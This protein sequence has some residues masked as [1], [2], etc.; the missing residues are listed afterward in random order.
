MKVNSWDCFDTL[1]A[2]NLITPSSIFDIVGKNIGDSDFTNKR[3]K[4][5]RSSSG[6]YLD[7]YKKL[8]DV[9]KDLELEA[10]LENC[11]PIIENINKVKDGDYI[12]SDM[13]LPE[14]FIREMLRK[15]GLKKDVNVVVTR[16][17]KHKGNI[18]VDLKDKILNHTGDNIR[19]DC[20]NAEIQGIKS[21]YYL[22]QKMNL[23]ETTIFNTNQDLAGFSRKLRLLQDD[24]YEEKWIHTKGFFKK[25]YNDNWYEQ[26]NT[27]L[28]SRNPIILYF[29]EVDRNENYILLK[30]PDGDQE[31]YVKIYKNYLTA[32][33]PKR[34]EYKTLYKGYWENPYELNRIDCKTLWQEQANI[35]I[36]SLI[37]GSNI[38]KDINPDQE[39]T[40]NYRDTYF[41]KK[42]YDK[43]WNKNSDHI[44]S[45]R[46]LYYYPTQNY[47]TYLKDKLK[48]NNVI[49]DIQGSGASVYKFLNGNNINCK[50]IFL[51]SL[52]D[53][54]PDPNIF[55]KVCSGKKIY[56]DIEKFNLY[57]EGTLIGWE[58]NQP[59]RS[60]L[61]CKIE[62]FKTQESVVNLACEQINNFNLKNI[63]NI[64]LM[65][66][67]SDFVTESYTPKIIPNGPTT[68]RILKD[69]LEIIGKLEHYK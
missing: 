37:I 21:T 46:F 5:E 9:N 8:P 10:E 29:K 42:I 65:K 60:P 15:C 24:A 12:V 7:I 55:L 47:I 36:P 2:R 53:T 20:R 30:R 61:E 39:Y 50:V 27:D 31:V 13:Y 59:I 35:N 4:A 14:S 52:R 6:T 17:G 33:F 66:S 1:I 62:I 23:P 43:L 57:S 68:A 69:G 34:K 54:A 40:F 22:E 49:V 63:N 32:K 18:W 58:N 44:H 11:Y 3:K 45:S 28:E 56:F 25:L 48:N 67:V 41:L 16:H 19:S 64:N 38:L 51:Y 26:L